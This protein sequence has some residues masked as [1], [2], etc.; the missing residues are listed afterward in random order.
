MAKAR[1]KAKQ[2]AE[3][4]PKSKRG[5]KRANAGR[6][7]S[8]A[9]TLSLEVGELPAD[10]E[11]QLEDAFKAIAPRCVA[12]LA[13]LANGGFERVEQKYQPA[14]LVVVEAIATDAKGE[15]LL[16]AKGNPV[17]IERSLYPNLP[18]DELVLVERKV[19]VAEPNFK[20]NEFIVNRV[21]GKPRQAITVKAEDDEVN[22]RIAMSEQIAASH[23]ADEGPKPG[24]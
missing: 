9:K 1:A 21:L 8:Q 16:D 23:K 14:G 11:S 18:P 5:G 24:G 10:V 15:T 7:P 12:N 6:K 13:Y 3:I 22:V 4:K 20:A 19:E 2:S 17:V